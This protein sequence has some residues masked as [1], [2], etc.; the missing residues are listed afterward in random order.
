MRTLLIWLFKISKSAISLFENYVALGSDNAKVMIGNKKGAYAFL[1]KEH[2]N[3]VV[4]GCLCHLLNLAAE[5]G[6]ATLPISIEELI[7][8]IFLSEKKC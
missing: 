2:D 5:K 6:S 8:Y 1:K 4:F 3:L 7:I